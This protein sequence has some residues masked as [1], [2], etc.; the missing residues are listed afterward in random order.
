MSTYG[1]T[2]VASGI[3]SSVSKNNVDLQHSYFSRFCPFIISNYGG[4]V[5][6]V[7]L[8]SGSQLA[9]APVRGEKCLLL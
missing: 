5:A 3:R 8:D 6:G 7:F 9:Q 2:R 4:L 1:A